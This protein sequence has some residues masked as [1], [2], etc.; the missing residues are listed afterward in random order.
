MLRSAD[1][2]KNI[3]IA[4]HNGTPVLVKDIAE[5]TLGNVAGRGHRRAG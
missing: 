2:I 1:E 3:V 5:V 4:A